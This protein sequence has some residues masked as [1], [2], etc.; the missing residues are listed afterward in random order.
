MSS[1][2]METLLGQFSEYKRS[3]FRDTNVW[4]KAAVGAGEADLYGTQDHGSPGG[5]GKGGGAGG[6]RLVNYVKLLRRVYLEKLQPGGTGFVFSPMVR[7]RRSPSQGRGKGGRSQVMKVHEG[8]G[9]GGSSRRSGRHRWPE[10]DGGDYGFGGGEE[11]AE[12]R[13]VTTP[14]CT[15]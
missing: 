6:G 10:D 1:E 14:P 13:L 4:R 5:G 15:C 9:E 11:A 8:G 2:D 7:R 12:P 3:M